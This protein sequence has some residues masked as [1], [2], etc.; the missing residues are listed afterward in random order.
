MK[1]ITLLK[2]RVVVNDDDNDDNRRGKQCPL[3]VWGGTIIIMP[4]SPPPATS[5]S[6]D[7][8]TMMPD[9][10][11]NV[12]PTAIDG[13][14]HHQEERVRP[15]HHHAGLFLAL[16]S[17]RG[18]TSSITKTTIVMMSE[19][20]RSL[21]AEQARICYTAPLFKCNIDLPLDVEALH[22][23]EVVYVTNRLL[24]MG[25]P[26]LQLSVDSNITPNRKLAAVG[27]MLRKRHGGHYMVWNFSEV[28]YD[29]YMLDN[30]VLL[31]KFP[32]SPLPP[33]GLLLKLLMAMESWLKADSRNI[34]VVHC[35]TGRG[36]TSTVLAAFL[37]WMGK[38]GF[39]DINDA[40]SYSARC[41]RLSIKSLTIPSQVRES[42]KRIIMSKAPKFGRRL[43]PTTTATSSSL[44]AAEPDDGEDS[45]PLLLLSSSRVWGCMPYLQLFKAR[46][47]I[48]TSAASVSYS[49]SID[50]LPFCLVFDGSI[51]FLTNVNIQGDKL[52]RCPHMTKSG[53]R[54]SM[55]QA[56]FHTGYVPPC[57]LRLTK[58]Q[59]NGAC[60]DRRFDN[61]FFVDLI[62]EACNDALAVISTIAGDN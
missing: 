55:F 17:L 4:P 33:L 38:A 52:L 28:D 45:A 27:H 61:D 16:S 42:L 58:A 15:Q 30:M 43:V 59:L 24:T 26:H 35:L 62:F 46:N 48:F 10:N 60:E 19:A 25:H 57:V 34:A 1:W 44:S 39:H 5:S 37:C 53:Q 8:C 29:A 50:N 14:H 20:Q 54:I 3:P 21:K 12:N 32:G 13:R 11:A 49:Q 2:Q 22:D 36:R 6:S 51:S 18:W 41:K 23:A 7:D 47:L 40:L 56:A 9:G 31:Y